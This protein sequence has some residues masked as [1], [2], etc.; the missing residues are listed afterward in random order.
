MARVLSLACVTVVL[1]LCA[2]GTAWAK[3]KIAVLGLEAAPGPSGAVDPATTQVA[4][5]ITR[6][7]RQRAQGA[8]SPYTIAPNSNKEL[9]DEKLLMS[10]DSEAASCMAVIGAG[11]AA[12]VLLYGRVEKRGELYRISLKRLD[13]KT[14]AVAAGGEEI[15]VGGGV[16]GMAKRLYSKLVGEASVVG[17]LAVRATTASGAPIGAGTVM[18]DDEPRGKLA[19]GRIT[20]GNL[21]EGRH[22]LAIEAGGYRRFEETV[23]IRG[24]EQATLNALLL[25]RDAPETSVASGRSHGT[26]WKWALAGSVVVAAVG[27]GMALSGFIEQQHYIDKADATSTVEGAPRYNLGSSDCGTDHAKIKETRMIT[28]IDKEFDTACS[29]HDINIAG[30]VVLG[31]GGAGAVLSLIMVIRDAGDDEVPATTAR[32]KRS[33]VAIAPVVTPEWTGASLSLRW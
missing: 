6:E 25:V 13:V 11:L 7:L 27:G 14:K 30:F 29:W 31:V 22:A 5:A 12:D 28:F 18:V 33:D 16:A 26:A 4:R 19:G 15:A 24:G 3:P 2:G 8:A 21:P 9:T 32:G 23:T 20:L 17:T 10:C 1:A